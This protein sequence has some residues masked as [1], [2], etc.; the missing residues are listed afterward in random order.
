MSACAID[1][2]EETTVAQAT[3]LELGRITYPEG[4]N[5]PDRGS[6]PPRGKDSMKPSK[7]KKMILVIVGAVALLGLV[8]GGIIWSKGGV[9]TIQTTKVARE[10]LAAIVT[11]SGEIKPPPASLANVNA[12][13]WA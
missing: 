9:V 4:G 11:A 8:L 3:N 7:K 12:N 13:S 6:S 1:T 5:E 10:D 2:K